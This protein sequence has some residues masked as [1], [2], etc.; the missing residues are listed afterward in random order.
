M[1]LEIPFM[2][3]AILPVNFVVQNFYFSLSSLEDR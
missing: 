3:L 1:D 2:D